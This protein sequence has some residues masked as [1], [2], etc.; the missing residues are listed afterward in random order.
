MYLWYIIGFFI[1]FPNTRELK[2]IVWINV[3]V[4]SIGSLRTNFNETWIKIQQCS[5][6]KMTLKM[7][8]AKWQPFV[9]ASQCVYI[10]ATC[11]CYDQLS[12]NMLKDHL[13][14]WAYFCV[15]GQII[16]TLQWRHNG[17]GAMTSQ[18]TSHHDFLLKRLFRRRSNTTSKLRATGLCAGNSPVT[19]EF[20]HKWPVAR[21]MF[22]FDD[23]IVV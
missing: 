22:P 10:I 19:G 8:F 20:P 12:L 18:I 16:F 3:G 17:R 9:S 4:L 2:A 6:N 11:I 5:W 21:K 23:V 13:L 15:S 7:H 14:C 1:P